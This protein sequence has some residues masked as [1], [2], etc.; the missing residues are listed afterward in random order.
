[1]RAIKRQLR[2]NT[3]T[4]IA[5]EYAKVLQ[6]AVSRA[7]R[8]RSRMEVRAGADPVVLGCSGFDVF[9]GYHDI[10]PFD[11]GNRRVL[12]SRVA[13]GADPA[14]GSTMEL[15]FFDLSAPDDFN[16]LTSTNTW[17]WQMGA[18]LQWWDKNESAIFFNFAD[19]SGCHGAVF[20]IDDSHITTSFC[21]PLYSLSPDRRFGVS[22]DFARL[23]RLR[24]GYGYVNF[25]DSTIGECVPESGGL[26]LVDLDADNATLA[27]GYRQ[28]AALDSRTDAEHYFNHVVWSP[29][30]RRFLFL[31]ILSYPNGRRSGRAYVY[32]VASATVTSVETSG[33]VSHFAWRG[34]DQI[35]MYSRNASTGTGLNLYDL[36][37]GRVESVARNLVVRDCHPMF[38]PVD[39]DLILLDS[40]P[41]R[42]LMERDLFVLNMAKLTRSE[43]AA[44][45]SPPEFSGERRCD[46]HPRWNRQ[47]NRIAIDSSHSG[48]RQMVVLAYQ[49]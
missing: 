5:I 36:G 29:D 15:G 46:L 2:K 34:N 43:V 28:M 11:E 9:F 21:L 41:R 38:S 17:C 44:L 45:Y 12:A 23:Q 19:G 27:V 6:I 35:L 1:M 30:S 48:Q 37:S 7:V 3:A 32:D 16:R 22:L 47:G 31:H 25:P 40:Y 14:Q 10:S 18:R 8:Q 26:W 33:Y 49:P 39:K 42:P 13:R 4:R 20:S 24:P